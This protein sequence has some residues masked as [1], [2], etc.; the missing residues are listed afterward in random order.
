MT[1]GNATKTTSAPP[2]SG[3]SAARSAGGARSAR[4][5]RSL[6]RRFGRLLRVQT[7]DL[8]RSGEP[9]SGELA[10]EDRRRCA[11][12]AHPPE[13]RGGVRLRSAGARSG[14]GQYHPGL[15]PVLDGV[16]LRGVYRSH[17]D[18]RFGLR[19]LHAGSRAAALYLLAVGHHRPLVLRAEYGGMVLARHARAAERHQ[20]GAVGAPDKD[21]PLHAR[22]CAPSVASFRS[23]TTRSWR[24]FWSSPCS[25]WWPVS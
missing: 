2:A 5:A 4:A 25:W 19:Q 6:R 7:G 9:E 11:V 1:N 10:G 15:L 16:L 13:C 8:L 14:G 23:T 18:C 20:R 17:L 3:G 22:V 12:R 24:R 21:L